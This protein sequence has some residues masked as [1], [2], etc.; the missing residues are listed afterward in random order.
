MQLM[1]AGNQFS[2]AA[3][4]SLHMARRTG[5]TPWRNLSA[6]LNGEGKPDLAAEMLGDLRTADPR[7]ALL[8]VSLYTEGS[9]QARAWADRF[10][11][12]EKELASRKEQAHLPPGY[13][14]LVALATREVDP[15]QIDMFASADIMGRGAA[16]E[17][18]AA[19]KGDPHAPARARRLLKAALAMDL[20]LPSLSQTWAMEVLKENPSCQWAAGLVLQDRPGKETMEQVLRTLRPEDST[21]ARLIQASLLLRNRE[22]KKASDTFRQVAAVEKN[23]AALLVNQALALEGAGQFEEALQIYQKVLALGSNPHA[24]NSAAYMVTLCSPGDKAQLEKARTWAQQAVEADPENPSYHDTRGWVDC[25]LGRS[26][27]ACSDLRQAVKG[28]PQSPEAHYHLG[29]AEAAAGNKDLAKEHWAAAVAWA[30]RSSKNLS[31]A[32]E[33][34]GQLAQA[35]LAKTQ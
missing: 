27:E 33:K 35:Q 20:G 3:E 23:N 31:P 21:M 10:A 22:F 8:G 13:R 16:A 32:A 4:L 2:A 18:I 14:L 30:E 7:T 9:P 1:T 28:Q 25:L 12:I 29:M 6:L 34:A 24:A 17:L 5:L 15:S 11:E 26:D 19:S